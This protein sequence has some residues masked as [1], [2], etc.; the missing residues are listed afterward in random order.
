MIG[1]RFEPYGRDGLAEHAEAGRLELTRD[2]AA[3]GVAGGIP[4][5]GRVAGGHRGRSPRSAILLSLPA[6]EGGTMADLAIAV[7][8]AV[9]AAVESLEGEDRVGPDLAY[10]LGALLK[11][12]A[13]SWPAGRPIVRLLRAA[14]PDPDH[15]LWRHV[16][17]EA[18]G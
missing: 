2:G 11:G 6:R 10:L 3:G 8:D 5:G 1:Y 17:V 4:W 13:C 12:S 16:E 14:Y 9:A 18:D 7:Y 15:P